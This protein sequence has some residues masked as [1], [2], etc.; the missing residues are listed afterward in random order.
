VRDWLVLPVEPD[1]LGL[2]A[3]EAAAAAV[4][5]VAVVA[6]VA[7]AAVAVIAAA[8]AVAAE[9]GEGKGVQ[10]YQPAQGQNHPSSNQ[11]AGA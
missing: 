11:D 10:R 6:V 4:A 9:S 1:E 8:A 2:L 3:G 5:V 7:A